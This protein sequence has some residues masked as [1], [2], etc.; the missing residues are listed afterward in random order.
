MKFELTKKTIV[1]C[2]Q[3]LLAV[4]AF[5]L[6]FA[7]GIKWGDTGI[8]GFQVFFGYTAKGSV[9][10]VTYSGASFGG[11]V[12]FIFMIAIIVLPVAIFFIKNDKIKMILNIV[13]AVLALIVAIFLFLGTTGLMFNWTLSSDRPTNLSLGAG[14]IVDAILFIIIAAGAVV[15]QF[16][17]KD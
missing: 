11:I 14:F 9:I 5:F 16:V 1:L 10:S 12:S 4:V 7:P 8:N 13:L 6:L 2:C 3:L 17:L 15:N